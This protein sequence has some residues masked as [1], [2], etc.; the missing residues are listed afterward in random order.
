MKQLDHIVITVRSLGEACASFARAGF[1]VTPGGRHEALPTEN[2]L[3]PFADG[4][5]LELLA[6]RDPTTRDEL[7]SLASGAGWSRHLRG[8]SAIARRFLPSLAGED[9]VV[10]WSLRSSGLLREAAHLRS[11]GQAAAGPLA[12]SRERPDGE[13]LAWSLLLP[14][15]RVLP[16]WIEDRTPRERRVPA[17]GATHA[18]GATGIAMVRI[19]AA[20]VPMTALAL[21]DVLGVVPATSTAGAAELLMDGWRVEVV[22]GEREGACAVG[23]RGY[24]G[25]TQELE[26]LGVMAAS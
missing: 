12:M 19:S 7:R 15:S 26:S 13:K 1:T 22:A 23:V 10:D 18:N 3:I 17:V 4:T 24:E 6:T 14:E 21:G 2:A 5:Y 25:L 20:S 11:H 16:F 8:V 9:G